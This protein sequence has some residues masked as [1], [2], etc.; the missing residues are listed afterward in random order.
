MYI[1]LMMRK[2]K[3][4]VIPGTP[5]RMLG[6]LEY[7][8]RP[9]EDH[10]GWTVYLRVCILFRAARIA[11]LAGLEIRTVGVGDMRSSSVGDGHFGRHWNAT[12]H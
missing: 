9:P 10:K 4:E 1:W 7:S 8:E 6:C 11:V 5:M 12:A 2:F 3:F